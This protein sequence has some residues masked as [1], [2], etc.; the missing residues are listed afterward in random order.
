M[1][2]YHRFHDRFGT[3]GVILGAIALILALGG[4]AFAASGGLTG[5]QKKEV[6]K[7]AKQYAGKNGAPGATGPQGA[8]GPAGAN[9]KDGANG[10]DG[11][12]GTN[13]TNGANGNTVLSGTEAPNAGTG[14]NGDFYIR[15]NTNQIYGPKTAGAWGAPT[16]LKGTNGTNGNTIL[17]GTAAPDPTEGVN[18][19]FYLRT[20]TGELYGPKASGSWG[21]PVSLEGPEGPEGSPWVA[22]KAPSG[23]V[24]KGTWSI[25]PYEAEAAGEKLYVP[26]STG[27][28]IGTGALSPEIG[29]STFCPGTAE[30]PGAPAFSNL[31]CLYP[32]EETKVK[33]AFELPKLNESGG[34]ALVVFETTGAG[35]AKAYG[36]WSLKT[37]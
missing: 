31:I 12:N 17:S 21:S 20:D 15:T 27:V 36:S 10:A 35:T 33:M 3:V 11:T 28:P 1:S 4:S 37:S 32:A 7:I 6:K 18:G 5:K 2:L 22:G 29:P 8:P 13:G 16:S 34:G 23:T 9:G 25:P 19:D 30:Q 24:M 26:I 14:N